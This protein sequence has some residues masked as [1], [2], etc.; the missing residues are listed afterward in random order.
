MRSDSA[1]SYP[2]AVVSE[3]LDPADADAAERILIAKSQAERCRKAL[4]TGFVPAGSKWS[5]HGMTG[6]GLGGEDFREAFLQR[7]HV[8]GLH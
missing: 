1:G 6:P 8:R 7:I 3:S 2:T 4:R 5:Q